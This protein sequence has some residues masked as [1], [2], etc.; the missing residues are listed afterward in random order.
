MY[1][2]FN[3]A[4]LYNLLPKKGKPSLAAE[5]LKLMVDYSPESAQHCLKRA[6][7]NL[8]KKAS[9]FRRLRQCFS[10]RQVC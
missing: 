3:T 5:T 10:E 2:D 4:G 8:S 7:H 9:V 6:A 1:L